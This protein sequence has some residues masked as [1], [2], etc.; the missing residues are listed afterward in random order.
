M[1]WVTRQK[2]DQLCKENNCTPFY[3]LSWG[4]YDTGPVAVTLI[5]HKL[6][7]HSMM[8]MEELLKF[9][10][11]IYAFDLTK[12]WED[13]ETMVAEFATTCSIMDCFEDG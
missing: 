13:L 12:P 9:K 7:D 8:S 2:I 4:G 1:D 3:G 6:R 11:E 10:L 5:Y